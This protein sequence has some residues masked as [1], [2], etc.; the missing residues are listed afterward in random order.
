MEEMD[1]MTN[2]DVQALRDNLMNAAAAEQ[3]EQEER[4]RM[5]PS[6]IISALT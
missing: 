3:L 6:Y 4:D 2:I 1:D 5:V